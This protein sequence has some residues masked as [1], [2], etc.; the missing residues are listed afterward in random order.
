MAPNA[1]VEMLAIHLCHKEAM[2]VLPLS[3]KN[4]SS[5]LNKERKK[6]GAEVSKIHSKNETYS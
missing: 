2:K 4:E 6:S 1:R 3:E 5:Q